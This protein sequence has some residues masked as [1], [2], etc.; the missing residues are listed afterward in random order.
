MA[1]APSAAQ[2][3]YMGGGCRSSNWGVSQQQLG[4]VAAVKGG[5]ALDRPYIYRKRESTKKATKSVPREHAGSKGEHRGSSIFLA[6][7]RTAGSLM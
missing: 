4:G 5:V 1:S 2:P 6:V 7:P 3:V